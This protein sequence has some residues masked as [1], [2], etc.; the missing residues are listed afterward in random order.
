[1]SGVD[2]GRDGLFRSV[3]AFLDSF[4]N[5]EKVIGLALV[6]SYVLVNETRYQPLILLAQFTCIFVVNNPL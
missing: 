6:Y 1:M 2:W 3:E 5:L 4:L